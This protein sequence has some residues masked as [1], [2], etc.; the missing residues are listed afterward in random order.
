MSGRERRRVLLVEDDQSVRTVVATHLR[1]RRFE[2][3]EAGAAE[4]VLQACRDGTLHYQLAL[5]DAHLP[6]MSGVD[7]TRLLLATSPLRPVLIIT[8]DDDAALAQR[9][10]GYGVAG[11]LLKP[12]QMFEL[13]AALAQAVAMLDLVETTAVL[14]RSQAEHLDDWGEAGGLLPRAWLRLGDEHSGAGAGHGA[15]VVSAAGLL[16]KAVAPGMPARDLDVLRTAA[17]THEMGRLLGPGGLGQVALRTAQLLTD[18]GFDGDVAE[19]VRQA[20]EPW[21]PGLSLGARILALA[22]RVDHE[23]VRRSAAGADPGVA[24]R[25]AIDAVVAVAGDATDPELAAVLVDHREQLESMWLVQQ[26]AV[27]S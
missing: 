16:A 4:E 22:D 19:V 14:A 18:L 1:K 27:P 9:A 13:D 12:F 2:V 3:V 21:S 24:I 5:V 25:G 7:L 10:L 6:G 17:R 15:R 20:A 23:A 26:D 11:Y 8:G